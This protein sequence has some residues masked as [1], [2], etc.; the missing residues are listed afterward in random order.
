MTLTGIDLKLHFI[1]SV[2]KSTEFAYQIAIVSDAS[3]RQSVVEHK[4][5]GTEVL[6]DGILQVCPLVK[7]HPRIRSI[8]H[9]HWPYPLSAKSNL[10]TR[11]R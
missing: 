4:K 8:E 6:S 10:K 11:L 9:L 3:L 7:P 1:V 2:A 5:W